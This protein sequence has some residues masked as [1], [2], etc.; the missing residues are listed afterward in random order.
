MFYHFILPLK[1]HLSF[2]R[3]FQYITFRSAYAA[4]TALILVLILGNMVIHWLRVL[5]FGE[6]I[7]T[8]GPE[9]HKHKAGTPTMGG[10]LILSAVMISILLWG[11]FNTRYLLYLIGATLCLGGLGFADDYIKS[12]L[13][14]KEGVPARVK[15][16]VQILIACAVALL[17]YGMPSNRVE[18]STL[19]VPF[20]NER[21]IER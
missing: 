19:Y 20:I 18:A 9:S 1:E 13:K 21:D 12:I 7:R 3:L 14:R 15:L 10:I 16:I 11:N 2:L 5:K 4:L 6:E 17:I 8:L